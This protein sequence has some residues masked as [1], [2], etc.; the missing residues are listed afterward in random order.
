MRAI[1][2]APSL[3]RESLE[4][5]GAGTHTEPGVARLVNAALPA[6][7]QF[8]AP[9]IAM[10]SS[11]WAFV[12]NCGTPSEVGYYLDAD[13]PNIGWIVAAE[14]EQFGSLATSQAGGLRLLRP[15]APAARRTPLPCSLVLGEDAALLC[16]ASLAIAGRGTRVP[17]LRIR[18]GSFVPGSPWERR[19]R[20]IL[21]GEPRASD[22][23]EVAMEIASGAML[24]QGFATKP[25]IAGYIDTIVR[26]AMRPAAMHSFIR[27]CIVTTAQTAQTACAL[28]A[29]DAMPL[30]VQGGGTLPM[31]GI[32]DELTAA[33]PRGVYDEI[34]KW[35]WGNRGPLSAHVPTHH[36]ILP[37]VEAM[38]AF[39]TACSFVPAF[40]AEAPRPD[41]AAEAR[42]TAAQP[43][44]AA[45][46]A[47]PPG[48]L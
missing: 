36:A 6:E 42:L 10:R 2:F 5:V 27:K 12:V 1:V 25:D 40:A 44:I 21:S 18:Q 29:R 35:W 37:V 46:D 9:A 31:G 11:F 28:A 33:L 22:E 16:H 7:W 38:G 4:L 24:W 19:M 14:R 8:L 43:V 34:Y 45:G 41:P 17:A 39:D 30:Y 23:S 48:G 3:Q 13:H 26:P 47:A 15:Y 32:R 20:K